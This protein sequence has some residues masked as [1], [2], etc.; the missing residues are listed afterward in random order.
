LLLH[1]YGVLPAGISL[2]E[3]GRTASI[4]GGSVSSLRWIIGVVNTAAVVFVEPTT[5]ICPTPAVVW[6][7]ADTTA[8]SSPLSDAILGIVVTALTSDPPM[9]FALASPLG[10]SDSKITVVSEVDARVVLAGIE[11]LVPVIVALVFC[12]PVNGTRV[13]MG[14]VDK[15]VFARVD[16][17]IVTR[18]AIFSTTEPAFFSSVDVAMAVLAELVIAKKE[19]SAIPA[20][21][22]AKAA[23]V[24]VVSVPMVAGRVVLA[25]EPEVVLAGSCPLRS[26]EGRTALRVKYL[27]ISFAL[28]DAAL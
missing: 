28:M 16:A 8:S 18:G 7:T 15:V 19:V 14:V 13:V 4:A 22:V 9:R 17:G 25:D 24:L 1:L 11:A 10:D 3:G 5:V 23:I 21:V 26:E 12:V 20:P 27:A 6:V 2:I